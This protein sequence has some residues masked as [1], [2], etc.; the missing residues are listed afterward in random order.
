[1]L[2]NVFLHGHLAEKFG[3]MHRFD[4]DTAA[5][6]VRALY[7]NHRT[8]L[9]E[10]RDHSFEIIRGDP[11]TGYALDLGEVEQFRLGGADLHFVPHIEGSKNAAAGGTLKLILGVGLIG[12]GLFAGL[13]TPIG[14]GLLG[15]LTY[16]NLAMV[17]V[18]L[19]VA[20][21]AT[22]LT[23]KQQDPYNQS[24]FTLSGPQNTYAQGNP[25]QLIYGE[26]ITGSL[27][28]S[29][30]MDIENIP[31]NWDPTNGNTAIDTYDP[32]SGQGVTSGSPTS[33][34]QPSGYT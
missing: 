30:A 2:R 4:V 16:G 14:G 32:E 34:T 20:G 10:L 1:M 26:V 33:Y 3:P 24:S 9:G 17:G 8:F 21:V 12:V 22:L 19:A 5:E 7:A 15:G 27:L 18:G 29:G 11:E 6:A 23:P 13:A 28:V 25:V 31:V